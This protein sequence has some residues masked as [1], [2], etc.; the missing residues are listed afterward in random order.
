MTHESRAGIH[1]TENRDREAGPR[2]QALVAV[3]GAGPR[4]RAAA[5]PVA[6]CG[7]YAM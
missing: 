3:A 5:H 7:L 1:R 2:P 6:L 4:R